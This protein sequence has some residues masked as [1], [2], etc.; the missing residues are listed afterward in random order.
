MTRSR[1]VV[2][3]S[4]WI[5]VFTNGVQADA[6]LALMADE[7]SLVVPTISIFEVVKWV[8]REHGEAQAIQAAAAM[9]RAQVVDLDMRLALAAAQLSQALRLPMAD[10]IILATARDQQARLY[11]MDSDFRGIADVEWIAAT[12]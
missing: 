12:P 3:S 6:F 5:E 11:T 4:G 10:S 9:Q 8:R 7:S 1:V 2:D